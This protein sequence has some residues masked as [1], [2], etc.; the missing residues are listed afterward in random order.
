[1]DRE[2]RTRR[3]N[4]HILNRALSDIL[5]AILVVPFGI[6]YAMHYEWR[7]GREMC[8]VW[9]VA[10][11]SQF[12]ASA[13]I[14]L[15]IGVDQLRFVVWP[16][17]TRQQ[18]R[19]DTLITA[20]I[21]ALPWC[22]AFLLIIPLIAD[23]STHEYSEI[24]GECFYNWMYGPIFLTHIIPTICSL[25][26]CISMAVYYKLVRVSWQR[27]SCDGGAE[28]DEYF[29]L[30]TIAT[31]AVCLACLL[32]WLPYCCYEIENYYFGMHFTPERQV[33]Y[34]SF[35]LLC[36]SSGGI[37][38]ILWSIAPDIRKG[39]ASLFNSF[40]SKVR[41]VLPWKNPDRVTLNSQGA[42]PMKFTVAF[43][44]TWRK[45]T[46][47][48]YITFLIYNSYPRRPSVGQVWTGDAGPRQVWSRYIHAT[49]TYLSYT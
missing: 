32:M 27:L 23:E 5:M 19:R 31:W 46:L 45:Y 48:L 2:R 18:S 16:A 36:V 26:V 10:D 37:S 1:M 17:E 35:Y 38:P 12:I 49:D 13:F 14:M 21:L 40:V 39:Y 44:S 41:N 30:S 9:Q 15:G 34:V 20:A 43:Q 24:P 6:S 47:Q 29:R 4:K 3:T 28:L 11:C 25:V 22:L 7:P 42:S 33:A 8:I